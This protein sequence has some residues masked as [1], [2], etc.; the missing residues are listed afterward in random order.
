MPTQTQQ[1]EEIA[2]RCDTALNDLTRDGPQA[3][4]AEVDSIADDGGSVG[5]AVSPIDVIK[6]FRSNP[7]PALIINRLI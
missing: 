3:D 7:F 6:R 1:A 4:Y 5:F 2:Q